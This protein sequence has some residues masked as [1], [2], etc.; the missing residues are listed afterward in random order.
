MRRAGKLQI[1]YIDV[2]FA[3]L[4]AVLLNSAAVHARE[5]DDYFARGKNIGDSID[6]INLHVN[7]KISQT[8][9]RINH[10]PDWDT[11]SCQQIVEKISSLFK[12]F[13]FHKIEY[14]LE[15]DPDVDRAPKNG[16]AVKNN[17]LQHIYSHKSLW[18]FIQNSLIP[19]PMASTINLDGVYLG[20]DKVGHFFASGWRYYRTYVKALNQNKTDKQALLRAIDYG[21]AQENSI[22]GNWVTGIFSPADLEAN[23]RGLLFYK[24]FCYKATPRIEKTSSGWITS[25]PIDLR[26]YINPLWD[27]SYN[28]SF[29]QPD[30]WAKIRIILRKF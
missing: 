29:F 28:V 10:Y 19:F 5:S 8:L 18:L 2:L 23:Y 14:F 13:V 21:I 11:H 30:M 7:T 1:N 24:S 4:F 17:H 16:W 9:S 12:F 20:T 26:G 15:H 6:I 27:E 25:K 22:L 3:G